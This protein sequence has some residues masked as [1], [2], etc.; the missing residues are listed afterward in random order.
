VIDT[1]VVRVHQHGACIAGNRAQ[2]MGRSR[3]GFSTKI[4][5]L[6][7]GKRLA[8]AARPSPVSSQHL[9]QTREHAER[10]LGDGNNR[11]IKS[12][13]RR[14]LMQSDISNRIILKRSGLTYSS[15]ILSRMN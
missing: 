9:K 5:A 15:T 4:H 10:T 1:S 13:N 11:S 2:Q 6:V 12:G 8:R 7:D 3:G 14:Q